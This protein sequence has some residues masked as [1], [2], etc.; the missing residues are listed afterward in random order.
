MALPLWP[1]GIFLSV[2]SLGASRNLAQAA[3]TV[4][5]ELIFHELAAQRISVNAEDFSGAGLVS[6]SAVENTLDETLFE[7]TNGLVEQNSPLNH[8]IDKPFQLIFHDGT[9]PS[10]TSCVRARLV[11]FAP[12]QDAIG[13][14]VLGTSGGNDL[15]R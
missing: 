5:I 11:Q 15:G 10:G 4:R 8:L 7:F 9:L 2:I 14:L 3:V 6:G 13:L 1:R 12:G